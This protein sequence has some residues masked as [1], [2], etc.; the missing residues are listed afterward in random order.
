[1]QQGKSLL[2]NWFLRV[3]HF[4]RYA[5]TKIRGWPRFWRIGFLYL[6]VVLLTGSIYLWR[7][8]QLR[9]INP[10]IEKINFGEL[11]DEDLPK[12]RNRDVEQNGISEPASTAPADPGETVTNDIAPPPP[13]WPVKNQGF[14]YR[15]REPCV[16]ASARAEGFFYG[17]SNGIA[18]QASPGDK[19]C[20][21]SGGTVLR[22]MDRSYPYGEAVKI[23]HGT[24]LIVYYGALEQLLVKE[25][26]KVVRG[27]PIATVKLNPEGE[28]TY[29]YLEIEE[30]GRPVDPLDVLPSS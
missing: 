20:S 10:Y 5:W 29:L 28:E 26:Q 25:G 17:W 30:N 8:A 1:M 4:I 9:T 15:Y 19:V 27:D 12:K 6:L 2:A 3:K 21:I 7:T 18:I 16:Q 24:G 22:I 11:E 13:A 23:E 14:V